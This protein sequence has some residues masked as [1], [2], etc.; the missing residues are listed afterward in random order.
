MTD[1]P[2]QSMRQE[3]RKTHF[4]FACFF[5]NCF[6]S[7]GHFPAASRASGDAKNKFWRPIFLF[8]CFGQS[9]PPATNNSPDLLGHSTL[10]PAA[11]FTFCGAAA[12]IPGNLP[13]D[14]SPQESRPYF[15]YF[16]HKKTPTAATT[17][18][19]MFSSF[20]AH[21]A[22]ANRRQQLVPVPLSIFYFAPLFAPAAATEQQP[23]AFVIP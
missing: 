16:L 7:I 18:R 22:V 21:E 23:A 8:S 14:V 4:G 2:R 11:V 13:A 1:E 12:P 20:G 9:F 17:I 6:P 19:R 5:L 10:P 3:S 15:F